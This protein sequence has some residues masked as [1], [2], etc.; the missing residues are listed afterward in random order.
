MNRGV[1]PQYTLRGAA[2][3]LRRSGTHNVVDR[4]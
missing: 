1:R 4:S 2:R 3:M